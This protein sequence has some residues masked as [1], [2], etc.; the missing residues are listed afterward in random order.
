MTQSGEHQERTAIV[1]GGAGSIG[2]AIVDRLLSEGTR[3]FVFDLQDNSWP[4][5]SQVA[6]DVRPITLLQV[7]VSNE[8]DLD[9]AFNSVASRAGQIDYLIFC[10]ARFSRRGFLD[11]DLQ[12]W[13]QTLDVNLTAAFLCCRSAIRYMRA[14]KFGRIVLFSS[15][16]ARTGTVNG[17]HYAAATGGILGLARTLAL[18]VAH[19][20]IRVNTISPGS[21][22]TIQSIG[23]TSTAEIA[24]QSAQIPLGRLGRGDDMVEACLFLLSQE[25]SYFTG[26]DIRING[27][28]PLW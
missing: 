25:S 22:D 4:G 14:Q 2:P 24:A 21:T 11:L 6:P 20:N 1:I 3:V 8:V 9:S 13:K 17:A 12:E 27:G 18:E 7:D 23:S 16:L 26:Q 19:E 15:M 28:A 5:P 10:A